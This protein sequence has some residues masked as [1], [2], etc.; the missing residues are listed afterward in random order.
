M[1]QEQENRNSEPKDLQVGRK[2]NLE[3]SEQGQDE[4]QSSLDEWR[5]ASASTTQSAVSA[6]QSIA[7]LTLLVYAIL[8]IN[9]QN[10]QG[11]FAFA[12]TAAAILAVVALRDHKGGGLWELIKRM[13]RIDLARR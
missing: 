8:M 12:G 2:K 3:E 6:I 4:K 13:L 5:R 10:P 1:T 11:L 7:T 9:G